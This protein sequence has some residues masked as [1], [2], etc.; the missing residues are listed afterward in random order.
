MN[1]C[2]SGCSSNR[3]SRDH[4]TGGGVH[5]NMSLLFVLLSCCCLLQTVCG[6]TYYVSKSGS[7]TA[8]TGAVGAPFLTIQKGIQAA[9]LP[10]DVLLVQ[11][12]KYDEHPRTAF[13][14]NASAYITLKA[15]G[16]VLTLG[17]DIGHL[18]VRLDGFTVTEYTGGYSGAILVRPGGKKCCQSHTCALLMLTLRARTA[19]SFAQIVNNYIHSNGATTFAIYITVSGGVVA[20]NVLI[21]V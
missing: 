15:N 20:N 19:G 10:G 9:K 17:F 6:A 21:Q 13:A 2:A 14:G 5:T 18:Y 12:G 3:F 1:M 16:Q 4:R 8:G 11:P 7:D